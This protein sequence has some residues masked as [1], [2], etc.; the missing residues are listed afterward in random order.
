VK[1]TYTWRECFSFFKKSKW[2]LLFFQS[3]VPKSFPF[4]KKNIKYFLNRILSF[5]VCFTHFFFHST[6]LSSV[7]CLSVNFNISIHYE[8]W[9]EIDS[10]PIILYSIDSHIYFNYFC[11]PTFKF[12]LYFSILFLCT[13]PLPYIEYIYLGILCTLL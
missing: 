8:P 5:F 2:N 9:I 13:V 12:I 6:V 1:I 4:F 3:P 11:E 10:E 7:I